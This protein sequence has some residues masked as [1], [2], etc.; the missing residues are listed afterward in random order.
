MSSMSIKTFLSVAS[1]LPVETSILLRGPH[2][3]GKS[4]VVRQV[5]KA[6][7]L[8]VTDRRLSQMS[9]GDMIGLPST[10]GET[11]RFNPPDWFKAACAKPICLF[12]DELNR[13]TPEVMQAAFQVVLDRELNG[14]KLHPQTRVFA[15]VNASAAYTVNEMDPALL[16]RFWTIDLTPTVEDWVSWARSEGK[17]HDY[18]VDFIAGNEKWLDTPKDAEPG[19]VSPSRRSWER[20][21]NALVGAGIADNP[22]DALFYPMCLGYVGPEATIAYHSFAKTIENQVTGEEVL[23]DY[24]KVKKKVAKLGQEKQN[25]LIEKVADYVTKGLKTLDETQ[26]KNLA[27]FMKDLPGELRVSAWSKLTQGSGVDNL[28]MAKSVHKYC[29]ETVLEVFGV[30]ADAAVK[31]L[32][33]AGATAKKGKK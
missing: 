10:D 13:A 5:A 31:A 20:L 9:E 33:G 26:G 18:V 2:G 16:D 7:G 25:V 21:S 32:A 19:K 4:Q 8:P 27:A 14:W 22:Q 6:F 23:R 28:E 17:V 30:S 11:T 1:K 12:L 24:P 3:I 29:V 15:A